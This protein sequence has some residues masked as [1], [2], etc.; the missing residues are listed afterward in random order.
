MALG[1]TVDGAAVAVGLIA[2]VAVHLII[3]SSKGIHVM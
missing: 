1:G 3:H 2:Q